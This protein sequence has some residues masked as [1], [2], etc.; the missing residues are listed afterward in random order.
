[1]RQS[2]T[3]SHAPGSHALRDG[4]LAGLRSALAQF[5][6]PASDGVFDDL[7]RQLAAIDVPRQAPAGTNIRRA[8]RGAR[9]LP[10]RRATPWRSLRAVGA[11]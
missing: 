6:M 4:R 3:S 10:K 2:Y 8:L 7:L 11:R 9:L 5:E 1:M